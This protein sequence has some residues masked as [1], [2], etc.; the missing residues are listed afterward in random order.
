MDSRWQETK[1]IFERAVE[2]DTDAR[3]A[4]LRDACA[5]DA[6]LE[7]EV[8]RML[9]ADAP[10]DSF[11]DGGAQAALG[12]TETAESPSPEPLQESIGPYRLLEKPGEG[13]MGEVWL[14]EQRQPVERKVALKIIKPGMDSAMVIARFSAERQALARMDH[15]A[16]A[17]VYD[18]G[19][20]AAGRP[21]FVMEY[22]RG[23]PITT[24][25]DRERLT[26]GERLGLL[27]EVCEGVQ[28]AH[29]RGIIHRDLKPS[30]VVVTQEGARQAPKI[31]DFGVAKATEGRRGTA[32][33][34]DPTR[35]RR[36]LSA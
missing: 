5:G 2:L 18:A 31:I 1:A 14:A 13:G 28:H 29:Q 11:L 21:Y 17:R 4:F 12:A 26:T 35:T 6:K 7:A 3:E 36:A 30:N 8:R 20:T 9:A 19:A 24:H 34:L 23:L 15:P 25:C 33:V 22:I 16:I 10:G 32:P 27:L